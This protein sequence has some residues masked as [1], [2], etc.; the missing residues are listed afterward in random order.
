MDV[1]SFLF[2]LSFIC[3]FFHSFIH[4][5]ILSFFFPPPSHNTVGFENPDSVGGLLGVVI[6]MNSC[7]RNVCE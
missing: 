7:N 4:S 3:S 1:F 6:V 5:F 2:F